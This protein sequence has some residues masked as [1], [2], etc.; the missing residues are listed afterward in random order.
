ML[1]SETSEFISNKKPV[2]LEIGCND[3]TDTLLFLEQYPEAEIYCFEPEPRATKRFCKTVFSDRA[4]LYDVAISDTDGTAIFNGSSGQCEPHRRNIN[5]Y[6]KL[7]EWDL[8]GS[9]CEPTGHLE[10]SKWVTFPKNRQVEV[11]T[12]RLDTWSKD[13][14]QI[15]IIDFIWADVQGAE[16]L[17][18]DGGIQTLKGTKYFYT[19]FY[20]TPMYEGQ[21]NLGQILDL[22]PNFRLVCQYGRNNALFENKL[23]RNTMRMRAR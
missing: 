1:V 20:P 8:S 3:G 19:E 18:I 22:L 4:H 5:H 11:P 21:P 14:P 15:K 17:L 23:P 7:P 12:I 2:I 13:N 9:L 10:M 6:T 16:K